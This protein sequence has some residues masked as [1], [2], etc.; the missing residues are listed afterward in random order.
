MYHNL[1]SSHLCRKALQTDVPEVVSIRSY[2]HPCT[3]YKM[4]DFV[5][6]FFFVYFE[7]QTSKA[8]NKSY[9][10]N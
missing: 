7:Y 1:F 8:A 10:F 2:V 3:V 4:I 5:T 9:K 6:L